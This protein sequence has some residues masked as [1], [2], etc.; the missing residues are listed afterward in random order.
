VKRDVAA[1]A[2]HLDHLHAGSAAG[3]AATRYRMGRLSPSYQSLLFPHTIF[4]WKEC[5]MSLDLLIALLTL[6]A[7]LIRLANGSM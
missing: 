3:L 4:F 5:L 1:D 2:Y 7:A 6:A